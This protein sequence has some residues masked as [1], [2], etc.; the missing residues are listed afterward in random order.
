MNRSREK[1]VNVIGGFYSAGLGDGT[2][3][4]ALHSMVDGFG[5][6][7]ADI[8]TLDLERGAMS[9]WS[10]YGL[11]PQGGEYVEYLHSFCPRVKHSQ[12]TETGDIFVDHD[13]I[14]EHEMDRHEVYDWMQKSADVRYFMGSRINDNGPFS[15]GASIQ[16][17]NSR[18]HVSA[19]DV[20]T[21]D[22]ILPHINNA[23]AI[24]SQLQGAKND[25]RFSAFM[26]SN[27]P[28]GVV[29][30]DGQGEILFANPF[31]ENLFAKRDGIAVENR[32]L[33]AWQASANRTLGYLIGEALINGQNH[34]SGGKLLVSRPSRKPG[35]AVQ[36]IPLATQHSA[37]A[38][39]GSGLSALVFI[40]DPANGT[41]RDNDH[42]TT[43]YGLSPAEATL[44]MALYNSCSLQ[45]AA[46]EIGIARN[47][48]RVQLNSIRIKTG[49]ASQLELIK[50]LALS[51][52]V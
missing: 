5:A 26:Q 28:W 45:K 6:V 2:W 23:R 38:F 8:F 30:L 10:G 11:L 36:V 32:Q 50:L 9:E 18:G 47:T 37:E 12:T 39:T 43:L 7:G 3:E 34:T 17:S 33:V 35:F 20:L 22:L 49:T 1:L 19:E 52:P 25:S 4:Q 27:V 14:S 40:Q 48:A 29:G 31:A 21:Y 51:R 13:L 24:E 15:T 44:A 41:M 42:L 46:D 16:F